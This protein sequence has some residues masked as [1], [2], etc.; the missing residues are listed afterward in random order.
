MEIYISRDKVYHVNDEI[1]AIS[2]KSY[3]IGER[4]GSG[5]NGA[6]YECIDQSESGRCIDEKTVLG[7]CGCQKNSTK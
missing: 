5:G 4:I 6:V 2:R 1:V 3:E 7:N